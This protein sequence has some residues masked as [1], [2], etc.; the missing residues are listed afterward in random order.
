MSTR[1]TTLSAARRRSILQLFAGSS[2][3]LGAGF[4]WQNSA[5]SAEDAV[6]IAPPAQDLTADG[7]GVQKAIF[8]GG[9]F[10]GVQGVFQHVKGVQRVVSGYSGGTAP[11]ATYPAVSGGRTAHAESVEIAYDPT[12]VSYGA[13]LQIFFSVAHDPTQLNRQVPDTGTQ[14]RS[15]I[16]ATSPAQLKVA[17]AYVAQLDAAKSFGKPIVTRLEATASFFPA[18]AYH[19]DFMT[20]NPRHPYIVINDLPKVAHLKRLFPDRYRAD[21]VLV[22]RTS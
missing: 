20:E 11:T 21:P 16:F 10:W 14:Y 9:C 15:A 2:L 22:K 4:F 12:Q 19:Q 7:Q 1:T 5:R 17:Q 13:L 6:Q 18:E 3:V 8:A